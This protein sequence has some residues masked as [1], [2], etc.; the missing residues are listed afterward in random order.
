METTHPK[1]KLG[2]NLWRPALLS[3][4]HYSIRPP[5]S[6]A[7]PAQRAQHSKESRNGWPGL[8]LEEKEICPDVLELALSAA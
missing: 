4:A 1:L 3:W 8:T 7:W 2:L 5:S 6:S